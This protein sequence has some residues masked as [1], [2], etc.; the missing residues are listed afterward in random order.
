MSTEH[1]VRL[2]PVVRLRV[3]AAALPGSTLVSR[4]LGAPFEEV[5]AVVEDLERFSPVYEQA[6]TQAIIEVRAGRRVLHVTYTV[7]LM[8]CYRLGDFSQVYP[9]ARGTSPLG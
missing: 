8:Q 1:A 3:L 4:E 9:L 2:D 5:W 7:L 6:V